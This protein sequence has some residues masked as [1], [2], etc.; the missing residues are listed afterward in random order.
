M[1]VNPLCT[2]TVT[3]Y[4]YTPQG[5]ARQ[6]IA[7]CFYRWQRQVGSDGLEQTGFLLV[8]PAGVQVQTGDR[9]YDGVGPE[10]VV[11]ERFLPV[12]TTGLGEVAYVSP[13]YFQGRLHH[14]EA[15]RK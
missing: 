12:N 4:R 6:V 14:I 7:G 9:V 1:T 11:W 2:Q 8:L 3:L 5:V 13:Y 15:G 10:Q